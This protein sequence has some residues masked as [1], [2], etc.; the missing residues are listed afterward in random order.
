FF[1]YYIQDGTWFATTSNTAL[2]SAGLIF[3]TLPSGL[4]L[5]PA[6]VVVSSNG[7]FSQ[8]LQV[9]II[10]LPGAPALQRLDPVSPSPG[11]MFVAYLSGQQFFTEKFTLTQ[12]GSI[13]SA[14]ADLVGFGQIGFTMPAYPFQEGPAQID[15]RNANSPVAASV[16]ISI[17]S[18]PLPAVL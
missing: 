18:Q 13:Y 15:I 17:P 3:S 5:G 4:S 16:A 8:P 14:L 11:Q 6:S 9:N 10:S 1:V 12:G 7:V 2:S